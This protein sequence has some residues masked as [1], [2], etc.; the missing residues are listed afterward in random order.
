M[1]SNIEDHGDGSY[2]IQPLT[3][4]I[5]SCIGASVLMTLFL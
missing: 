1:T 3:E 2:D 5:V 4:V